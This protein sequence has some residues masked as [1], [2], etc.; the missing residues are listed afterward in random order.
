MLSLVREGPLASQ[1]AKSTQKTLFGAGGARLRG[2][3]AIQ[4]S[5]KGS[6]KVLGR[7]LGKGSQKGSEKVLGRLWV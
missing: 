5:K 1:A 4:R 6:E 2:C 7:L 3:T